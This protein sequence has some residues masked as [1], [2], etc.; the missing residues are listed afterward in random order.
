MTSNERASLAEQ[1]QTNPL[2]DELFDGI[3][4]AAIEA[5][6][7]ADDEETRAEGA[8]RIRAIRSLRDDC[9]VSLRSIRDRKAAPA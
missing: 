9:G 3:E 1:L 4:R 7:Y 8:M 5:M 2:F 6:I